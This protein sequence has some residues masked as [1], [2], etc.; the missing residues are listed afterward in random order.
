MDESSH[1][2]LLALVP[3]RLFAG[4]ALLKSGLGMVRAHWLTEPKLATEVGAWVERGAPFGWFVPFL[5]GT[6]LTH[7]SLFSYLVVWG[8]ILV[9]AAL[10]V[11]LFT[12]LAALFGLAMAVSFVLAQGEL[13]AA[14]PAWAFVAICFTLLVTNPGRVL[15]IDQALRGRVPRWLS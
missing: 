9:G 8:E 12:R 5:K 11:G 15:G 6:V 10:L 7:A 13:P 4:W 1:V 3:L 2:R 14:T